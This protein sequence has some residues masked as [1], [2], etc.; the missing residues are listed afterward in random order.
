MS[1]LP[2]LL[3]IIGLLLPLFAQ[4]GSSPQQKVY[5]FVDRHGRVSFTDKPPHDGYVQLEKTHKGWV[6]PGTRFNYRENKKKYED[7][8]VNAAQEHEVPFWLISAVIHAESLYNPKAVSSAGAVALMQLMPCTARLYGVR[9]RPDPQ[10]NISDGVR[11]HKY[12]IKMF[13]GNVELALDAYNAGENAVKR[14]GNRIPPYQET[15]HYVRKV[16][17]LSLKYKSRAI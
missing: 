4:A 6:D 14:H 17:D 11:Y 12:S 5:K 10:Q 15:Q 7:I 9:D 8:I 3:V 2:K 13:A 1:A 16:S